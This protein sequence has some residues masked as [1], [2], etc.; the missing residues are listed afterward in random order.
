MAE[1]HVNGGERIE[2]ASL[3]AG[4][5]LDHPLFDRNGVLLL[6]AGTVLT[7]THKDRLRARGLTHAIVGEDPN[8]TAPPTDAATTACDPNEP[9]AIESA[10]DAIDR[11]EASDTMA[12]L[13][14]RE[15]TKRPG[16]ALTLDA[17]YSH[18]E[19][20]SAQMQRDAGLAADVARTLIR[21]GEIDGRQ[22]TERVRS[23]YELLQCDRALAGHLAQL[24]EREGDYLFTHAVSSGLV[25]M[26]V[27]HYAGFSHEAVVAT[28]VAALVHDT[29]MLRIDPH[30]RMAD[31]PLSPSEWF[32]VQSHP[33]YTANAIEEERSI[34]GAA[35]VIAYQVHERADGSGYPRGRK[36]TAIHPLSRVLGI[37]DSYAAMTATRPHRPAMRP[38]DAVGDLLRMT[39]AGR[40]DR[41]AMRWF[42]EAMGVFPIGSY[43]KL[44]RHRVGR[45]I[46]ANSGAIKRPVVQLL[47]DRFELTDRTLDLER[48][49]LVEIESVIDAPA[50]MC[51]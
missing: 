48:S 43:V 37:A 17:L 47:D 7:Q 6:P 40:Y 31:R 2:L 16:A 26:H 32:E 13:A 28:G 27:A 8:A 33:I 20:G 10:T 44:S 12:R 3:G 35:K 14:A 21:G 5:S 41:E 23:V 11:L 1:I 29:G 36:G 24:D 51:A 19:A 4:S 39:A 46:R 50:T 22:L 38:F 42:V 30:V 25:A 18:V 9:D 45:V 15:S 34:P 49:P